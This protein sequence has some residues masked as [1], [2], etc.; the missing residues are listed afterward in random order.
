MLLCLFRISQNDFCFDKLITGF[1]VVQTE[2][3]PRPARPC[4]D[5]P[6]Y[7]RLRT[8]R[9]KDKKIPWSTP[10][11]SY[12]K[13]KIRPEYWFSIPRNRLAAENSLIK[14]ILQLCCTRSFFSTCLFFDTRNWNDDKQPLF[15]NKK[16]TWTN[17][18]VNRYWK[19]LCIL[20][21]HNFLSLPDNEIVML[22]FRS[23]TVRDVCSH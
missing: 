14:L 23:I 2:L 20:N 5:P 4:E 9:P 19:C 16:P 21:L 15:T 22:L 1:C 3:I 11:M 7:L 10:I 17:I 13:K 12:G 8:G 6:L 18:F